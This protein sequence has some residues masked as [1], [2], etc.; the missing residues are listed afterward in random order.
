[1]SSE[2]NAQLIKEGRVVIQKA[3]VS[4]LPFPDNKFDLVTAI[5]TQYYWP[6]L[7]GDMHEILRVLKP[8]G[9]LIVVAETYKGGRYDKLKWPVM[10]LL[11]SSHLSVSEHR[12]LLL[13]AG[14]SAIEIS[15]EQNKGWISAI[16][17]KPL[18]PL[19]IARQRDDVVCSSE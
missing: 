10:K 13:A 4:K 5:E 3:S 7:V 12:E 19:V 14:Y 17:A 11:G 15:E 9:K 6:D 8:G 1:M 16:A 2:Q 18:V